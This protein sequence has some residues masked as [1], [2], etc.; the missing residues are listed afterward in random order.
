[1][2]ILTSELG[3]VRLIRGQRDWVD[4]WSDV[5][6]RD[7]LENTRKEENGNEANLQNS[8]RGDRRHPQMQI[9]APNYLPIVIRAA[10]YA[11]DDGAVLFS[12]GPGLGLSRSESKG[13]VE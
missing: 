4:R 10:A 12:G 9:Q 5:C 11:P 6:W 7:A 8:S 1:M 13:E 3:Y 2:T